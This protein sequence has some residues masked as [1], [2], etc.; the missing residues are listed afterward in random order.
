VPATSTSR[1][2]G[3]RPFVSAFLG[4]V[5]AFTTA[6][7]L[8]GPSRSETAWGKGAAGERIV[9]NALDA[10]VRDGVAV[11]HDRRIPGSHANID[12]LVVGPAGVFP[13]DAKH[14]SGRL[15]VRRRGN[16]LRIKGR[17]R[18]KLLDQAHRQARAVGEVLGRA[19]IDDVPV[20][21]TLCFVGTEMS[22]FFPPTEAAGVRLSTPR[23]LR[24]L[25]LPKDA[26]AISGDRIGH[27][28]RVL[29]DGFR[30]AVSPQ[31]SSV[32]DARVPAP[33][34]GAADARTTAHTSEQWT[35]SCTCGKP[36]VVR[37][38]RADGS[39][40]YGC[41]NFPRCRHTRPIGSSAG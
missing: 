26:S 29:D 33:P 19:G 35:P 10:L 9:G 37:T 39:R 27:V 2:Y 34:V 18:S 16:D 13:I 7:R 20:W 32:A 23:R 1:P 5:F 3:R 40:F 17:D 6:I 38:R 24:A 22:R 4:S 41:S 11:L 25:L 28:A 21:P 36:M 12:H 30:P 15:E 31:R 8:L 14:Y